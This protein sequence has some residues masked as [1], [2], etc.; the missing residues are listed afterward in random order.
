M[1]HRLEVREGMKIYR[2]LHRDSG[3]VAYDYGPDW[4]QLQFGLAGKTRTYRAGSIGT[5]NLNEMKRLA[6]LGTGLTTFLNAHPT[7]RGAFD[8]QD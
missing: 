8:P 5:D 7:I 4:I 3:I 6:D 1:G 2:N